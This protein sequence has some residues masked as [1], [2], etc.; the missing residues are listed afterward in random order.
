MNVRDMFDNQHIAAEDLRDKE[1]TLTISKVVPG[2]LKK[3]GT[4]K[5]DK[6][7]ILSFV[8]LERKETKDEPAKTLVV[9]RTNYKTIRALYGKTA[10][11]WIG[12]RI[13]IFPTTCDSFGKKNVP[14]IRVKDEEPLSA[15]PSTKPKQ[16]EPTRDVPP[17]GADHGDDELPEPPPDHQSP[18]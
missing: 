9:N 2:K 6:R 4:S 8:E 10:A 1:V 12:K 18:D 14:C 5:V 17:D 15:S 11:D 3:A 7:P 16:P 13:T